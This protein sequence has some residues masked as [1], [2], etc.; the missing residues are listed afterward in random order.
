MLCTIVNVT[1]T[2]PTYD[3]IS[4]VT[5]CSSDC[6]KRQLQH[7]RFNAAIAMA[8]FSCDIVFEKLSSGEVCVLN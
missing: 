2:V 5:L 1:I 6:Y 4:A 7:R 8:V 3:I